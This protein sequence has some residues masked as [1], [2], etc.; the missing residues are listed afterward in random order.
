MQRIHESD[1]DRDRRRSHNGGSSQRDRGRS[2]EAEHPRDDRG[3]FVDDDDDREY[4]SSRHGR[5]SDYHEDRGGYGSRDWERERDDR[6]LFSSS[7][8]G[9]YGDAGDQRGR[10]FRSGRSSATSVE[11]RRGPHSGK[12]PKG[13]QRSDQRIIEDVNEALTQH[14][15]LDATEIAVKCES[16]GVVVLSGTVGSRQEKRAAEDCIEDLHGVND[17]RNELR[18]QSSARGSESA[19]RDG[20]GEPHRRRTQKSDERTVEKS[21][22]PRDPGG[23]RA[24]GKRSHR[25][26]ED[27]AVSQ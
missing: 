4:A 24:Q 7:Y 3:R 25:E 2:F 12:G 22:S 16:G 26:E 13:Y 5:G 11:Q 27:D 9:E 18:V 1:R 14:G 8:S 17:V 21:D 23:R 19:E 15:D 10:G 20:E 6:G